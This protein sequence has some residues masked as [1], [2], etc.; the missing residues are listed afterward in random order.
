MFLDIPTIVSFI[1]WSIYAHICCITCTH[2]RVQTLLYIQTETWTS[3]Q[4]YI[5]ITAYFSI[6]IGSNDYE[7]NIIRV[8]RIVRLLNTLEKFSWLCGSKYAEVIKY[9]FLLLEYP[10][11][12]FFI[13]V[14]LKY[15]NHWQQNDE[16]LL[17]IPWSYH[18]WYD[19]EFCR[20][21]KRQKKVKL[22]RYWIRN[23]S[24]LYLY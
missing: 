16:Y 7:R 13:G 19:T 18:I 1:R 14:N 9:F 20:R 17:I 15:Q 2:L 4:C 8:T 3:N 21:N 12:D 23:D 10:K 24:E 5:K 11:T 22:L 6:Y